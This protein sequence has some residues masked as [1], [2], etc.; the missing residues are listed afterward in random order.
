MPPAGKSYL[1]YFYINFSLPISMHI[2]SH[3]ILIQQGEHVKKCNVAQLTPKQISAML[4]KSHPRLKMR[5][6]RKGSLLPGPHL[7]A[8]SCHSRLN[9]RN[10]IYPSH[11]H[12]S[13]PQAHH[14]LCQPRNPLEAPHSNQHIC[15]QHCHISPLYPS[16]VPGQVSCISV[17]ATSQHV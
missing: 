3:P 1:L 7:G 10:T 4:V 5:S 9:T 13:F 16:D 12:C 8:Q 15:T 14:T 2:A 17:A 11:F 6:P